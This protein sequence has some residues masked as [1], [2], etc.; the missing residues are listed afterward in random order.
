MLKDRDYTLFISTLQ[1]MAGNLTFLVPNKH[2][3]TWQILECMN[4]DA[5]F[6]FVCFLFVLGFFCVIK[7][8]K[9]F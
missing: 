4:V 2:V 1:L 9:S 7:Q 8:E 6:F 3:F 5:H